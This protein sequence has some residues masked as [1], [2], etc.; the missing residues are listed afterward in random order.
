[1][2]GAIMKKRSRNIGLYYNFER[3]LVTLQ[4]CNTPGLHSV[5]FR[6]ILPL[7][8]LLTTA[9]GFSLP[10]YFIRNWWRREGFIYLPKENIF[11]RK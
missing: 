10:Y 6:V 7:I 3:T 1:M 9:T 4:L 2:K 5:E 8:C 11:M